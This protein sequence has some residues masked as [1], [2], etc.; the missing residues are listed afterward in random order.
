[1]TKAIHTRERIILAAVELFY[2][3]GYAATGM[4]DI[5]KKA[6]AN[7]GS[8]YFFFR[9]KEDLLDAVLDWY[10]ANLDPILIR[11]LYE[12]T[13]DPME[14]IF[15]LLDDYRQK[16]LITDFAFTCPIGRLAL[17]IDPGKKKI[18]QKIAANFNGWI[19]AVRK[20]LDDA[21]D[22]LPAQADR[23]QLAQ[24]VLTVME[25]GV[26]QSRAQQSIRPFDASVEQLR[27]YFE[28]LQ[29]PAGRANKPEIRVH[30]KSS[31]RRTP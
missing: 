8:F 25:G 7:S 30:S 6:R 24:L 20:C 4:A 12:R 17:E 2:N 14:R 28:H 1:M 21:A 27:N 3:R 18:H 13:E 5:L 22:R 15:L 9:S 23:E 16:I 19:A 29:K 31:T 26:M 11:P 10:L